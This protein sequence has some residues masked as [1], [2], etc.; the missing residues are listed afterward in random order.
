LPRAARRR[1]VDV[2]VELRRSLGE[3]ADALWPRTCHVCGAA[4]ADGVACA[5]HALPLRPRGARCERC[6]AAL[7]PGLP[8]GG[9]CA[10]CR[11]RAPGWSRLVALGDYRLEPGLRAWILAFKHGA[12]PDLAR[13]LGAA[14]A[15]RAAGAIAPGD[16]LVP[17]PPHPL[18]RLERGYD[19]AALLARELAAHSGA[20]SLALLRRTRDTPAQGVWGPRSRTSNVDHAFAPALLR[21]RAPPA[22]LWLVDDVVT[23]GATVAACARALRALGAR[24]V[25]VLALA[26]AAGSSDGYPQPP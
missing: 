4:S 12:R 24:E 25:G 17:V 8:D 16:A 23:S 14:L 15:V 13:G 2:R 20:P 5:A 11:R 22:R 9:R 19:Q 10:A 3:L 18:R 26:R 21:R 6:A 7:P 1:R